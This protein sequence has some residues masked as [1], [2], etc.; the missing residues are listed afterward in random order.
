MAIVRLEGGIIVET[1]SDLMLADVPEH[2]RDRWR[3]I[4]GEPPTYDPRVETISGPA[5]L[6]EPDR[7]VRQWTVHRKSD[8]EISALVK[9]E[10]RR[11]ILE[12]FPEWKQTNMTARGVELQDVWRRSG[13]WTEA[14][15]A[16]ADA[17]AAAWVWIKAVRAASD[18]IEAMQPIPADY[19]DNA[20][21]P[22]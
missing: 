14:Q 18:V 20:R 9:M 15:Q 12:R 7:V 1:R 19:A 22:T 8:A 2:K 5:L 6:I 13:S 3:Q 21:W 17:L 16:E 4:E 10:C 11:R